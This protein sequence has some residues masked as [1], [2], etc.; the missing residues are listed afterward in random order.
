MLA[1]AAA[2]LGD[3]QAVVARELTKLY[4]E[5]R[6]DALPALAKAYEEETP[7]GEIVV[8]IGPPQEGAKALAEADLDARITAT[9]QQHS[10]KDTAAIV[11]AQ[12]GI[13]KREV[14]ARAL[15]LASAQ[16][17]AS[18]EIKL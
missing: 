11:S 8:L 10:V 4:E 18:N 15:Q 6:R 1:D 7:R 3:R 14:Y 16:R 2:V 5:V 9:L 17:D 12:T 13:P